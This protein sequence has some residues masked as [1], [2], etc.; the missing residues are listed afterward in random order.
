MISVASL[1]RHCHAI[2]FKSVTHHYG[3]A[4]EIGGGCAGI[5]TLRSAY[6]APVTP[7]SRRYTKVPLTDYGIKGSLY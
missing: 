5:R 7:S 1:S 4:R 3:V 6:N 2:A